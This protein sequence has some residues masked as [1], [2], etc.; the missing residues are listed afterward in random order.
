MFFT[1]FWVDPKEE[2]T[3]VFMTQ[4]WPTSHGELHDKLRIAVYQAI[5]D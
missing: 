1:T 5:T 4:I 2:I 3:A